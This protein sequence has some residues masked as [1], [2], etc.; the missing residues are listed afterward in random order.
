MENLRIFLIFLRQKELR[1]H[2]ERKRKTLERELA[3]LAQVARITK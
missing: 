2:L 1:A 3:R